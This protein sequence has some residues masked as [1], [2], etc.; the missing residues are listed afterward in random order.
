MK[1]IISLNLCLILSFF[2]LDAQNSQT[3][4]ESVLENNTT[5]KAARMEID[6]EKLNSKTGIYLPNPNV[7]FSYT[8]GAGSNTPGERTYGIS[9]S[10]EFPTVYFHKK[11]IANKKGVNAECLYDIELRNILFEAQSI[12]INLIYCNILSE[13]LAI[14]LKHAEDIAAAYEIRFANEDCSILDYNKAKL[15]LISSKKELEKVLL[16]KETLSM[17]LI[18]LNGGK[19]VELTSKNFDVVTLPLGV[20]F[21]ELYTSSEVNNPIL[22]LL[23][24]EIEVSQTEEKLALSKSLPNFSVGYIR[25]GG[26][27]GSSNGV[28]AGVTIPLWENKNT[29][30][31]AKARTNYL[32]TSVTDKKTQLYNTIKSNY[33]QAVSL[34]QLAGEYSKSLDTINNKSLLKTALDLGELSLIEY[35][36]E[37]SYYYE[38]MEK[39]LETQREANLI[40]AKLLQLL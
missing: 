13:E 1:K 17:E 35:L 10:F 7:D 40:T 16:E 19:P 34:H 27:G 18:R 21:E 38:A 6:A 23:S 39:M 26:V 36:M 4:I 9:Q 25:G 20:S 2:L 29:I 33:N 31:A 3:I 37:I 32:E 22:K 8:K 24:G 12:C 14:R 28:S 11:E 5:L 15:N 30:K